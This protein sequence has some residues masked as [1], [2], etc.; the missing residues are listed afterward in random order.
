VGLKN[1][2]F[3]IE[4]TGVPCAGKSKAVASI[5]LKYKARICDYNW[6]HKQLALDE[7]PLYLRASA[8][9][10]YLF[11]YGIKILGYRKFFVLF[12]AV[13][14]S[15]WTFFRK[16]NVMRNVLAKYSIHFI[17]SSSCTGPIVIDEGISHLPFIFSTSKVECPEELALY[18]PFGSPLVIKLDGQPELIRQRL[19]ERGHKMLSSYWTVD[20]FL[21]VNFQTDIKQTLLFE[22]FLKSNFIKNYQPN[23]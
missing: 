2:V 10:I 4:L 21:K 18:F 23:V 22:N 5:A 11:G 9:E 19:S 12:R 20:R 16:L 1:N 6:L 8:R 14:R 7:L 15:G 3:I 17:A 13:W